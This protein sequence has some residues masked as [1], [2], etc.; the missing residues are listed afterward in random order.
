VE[1]HAS[2]VLAAHTF[3]GTDGFDALAAIRA[4][5]IKDVCEF[6]G[7][8][9]AG[10]TLHCQQNSA[11]THKVPYQYKF[12]LATEFAGF[13]V[14]CGSGLAEVD[15]EVGQGAIATHQDQV[16]HVEVRGVQ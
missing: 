11:E 10:D 5:E 12:I 15:I 2:N 14:G 1:Y 9:S 8:V 3:V 16:G 6:A 7:T 13:F 4:P